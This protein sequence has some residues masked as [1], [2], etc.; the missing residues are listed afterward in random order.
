MAPKILTRFDRIRQILDAAAG[1]ST[2]NYGGVGRPWR[3]T[4]DQ[5]LTVEV[6][7]V[8][9]VAPAVEEPAAHAASGTGCGCGCATTAERPGGQES[10]ARFPRYPGRGAASGLVKGLRGQAPYDGSVFPRLPWGGTAVADADVQFISDWI[11]DGLPGDHETSLPAEPLS[12]GA[13]GT[14]RLGEQ[15]VE[16]AVVRIF[17]PVSDG[18]AAARRPGEVRQRMNLD[19]MNDT[20]HE[21]LRAAF[22]ELYALNKWPADRRSYNNMALI[23]QDHCQHGWERFLPWHRVYLYEMEQVLQDV[24]PGVTLPYWDFTMPQYKPLCPAD[25]DRIPLSYQ[26]FLTNAAVDWL[27]T[28]ADPHLPPDVAASVRRMVGNRY[29]SLSRFFAA[30]TGK[31]YNVPVK[32]T[33]KAYRRRFIDAL[34]G[35]NALWYPLRWPGEY[36]GKSIN[37][38]VGYHYPKPEDL[39]EILSLTTFRDFGGGPQYDVSFGFLDQNPHNT[40]HIW[41]GGLNPDYKEP[42]A[43]ASGFAA[44]SATPGELA[45]AGNAAGTVRNRAVRARDRRFHTRDDMYYEQQP[46]G[47]MLSNLTASFDPV[48][49]PIHVNIDRLWWEWQ[50]RNPGANPVDLESVL[51]P[52]SYTVGDTLEISR[53][54]YEYV[55]STCLIPVGLEAPVGRFVSRPIAV[56][57]PARTGFRTAE[58]RLLGVPQLDRS[59][60]IRVFLNLPDANGQTPVDHPNYAGYLAIFGHGECI[61]GPGHCAVPERRPYDLRPRSHNT[62]RNHRVNVTTTARRLLEKSKELQITLVVIGADYCEDPEVLRLEGVSLNFLD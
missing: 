51:T 55:R 34:L 44:E 61:G 13:A 17:G 11:D 42:P 37:Q 12:S 26:C 49:W 9:M 32:Y 38:F 48:F 46:T 2:S 1:D 58:V 20:Q 62:P 50:L 24:A 8:R 53:F 27:A 7:G 47:D 25:G 5:L 4:R 45:A 52:W 23:H 19:C 29:T 21:E 43:P 15:P 6:Y 10:G 31:P 18:A 36:N 22:R 60:F 40:M 30:M 41:T 33:Q 54:G 14:V 28:K 3:L 57:K 39:R 35:T 56:P 16:P 59:C